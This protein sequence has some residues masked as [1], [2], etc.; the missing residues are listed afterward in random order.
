MMHGIYVSCQQEL[1]PLYG[2]E[3]WGGPKR[4]RRLLLVFEMV[5]LEDH[6]QY[7]ANQF[8]LK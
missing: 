6:L 1:F 5:C 7:A 3:L 2:V 4:F 8:A